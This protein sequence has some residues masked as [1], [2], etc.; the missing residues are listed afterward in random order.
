VERRNGNASSSTGLA[1]MK[2]GNAAWND[3]FGTDFTLLFPLFW[4]L[5]EGLLDLQLLL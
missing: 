4:V 3:G 2:E 5:V 1:N